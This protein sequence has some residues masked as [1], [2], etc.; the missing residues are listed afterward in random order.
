M[1]RKY[2]AKN[3]MWW[4]EGPYTDEE[5]FEFFYKPGQTPIAFTRPG[6]APAVPDKPQDPPAKQSS[7]RPK[8]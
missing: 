8:P 5:L 7:R 4:H 6:P 3:D 2:D 1:V